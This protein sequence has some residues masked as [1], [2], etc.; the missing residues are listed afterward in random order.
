MKTE[1][2]SLSTICFLS[3]FLN[4][5]DLSICFL[6]ID[7]YETSSTQVSPLHATGF[8][9]LG[10]NWPF[11]VERTTA[12][13]YEADYTDNEDDDAVQEKSVDR[14]RRHLLWNIS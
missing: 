12:V 5:P 3:S 1:A 9:R 4:F 10:T 2:A 13:A 8:L 14:D 6:F 11:Q 7:F